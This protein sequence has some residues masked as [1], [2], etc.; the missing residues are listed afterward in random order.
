M[1]TKTHP[2]IKF[3]GTMV[4]ELREF[5]KK[6]KNMDK[7]AKLFI[8]AKKIFRMQLSLDMCC[9]LKIVKSRHNLKLKVRTEFLTVWENKNT[10]AIPIYR[11]LPYPV[12][13]P[14]DI[15]VECMP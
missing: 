3:I 6:K 11:V 13:L 12:I 14:C 8:L 15:H 10:T 4:I 7:M 1:V 9:A 2:D 5:K